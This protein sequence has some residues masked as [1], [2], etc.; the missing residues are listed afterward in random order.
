MGDEG[1]G[2][3]ISSD[4]VTLIRIVSVFPNYWLLLHFKMITLTKRLGMQASIF[5]A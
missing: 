5:D 3:L 1:G 4:G 2:S